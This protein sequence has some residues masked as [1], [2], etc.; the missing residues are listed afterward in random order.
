MYFNASNAKAESA[1]DALRKA[2]AQLDQ[3]LPNVQLFASFQLNKEVKLSTVVDREF[4]VL[5]DSSAYSVGLT[6]LAVEHQE[7]GWRV[8][9]K[10][11]NLNTATVLVDH[12]FQKV[13]LLE[14]PTPEQQP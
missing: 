6:I 4:F 8:V 10:G 7:Q 5:K 14:G 3:L 12:S 13:T 2:V 1:E 9:V 11:P